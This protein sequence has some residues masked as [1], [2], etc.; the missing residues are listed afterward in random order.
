MK[1]DFNYLKNKYPDYQVWI[2][3][4]SLGGAMASLAASYIATLKLTDPTT[5]RLVTIGQPRTGDQDYATAHD[6]LV[7]KPAPPL[8]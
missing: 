3:G 6:K 4:H 7:S 8:L 1:N 5:M 2:A